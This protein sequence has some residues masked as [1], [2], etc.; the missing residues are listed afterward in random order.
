MK[1]DTP[2]NFL[3]KLGIVTQM[4]DDITQFR[5]RMKRSRSRIHDQ[6]QKMKH[7]STDEGISVEATETIWKLKKKAKHEDL[8]NMKKPLKMWKG[9]KNNLGINKK[10][11]STFRRNSGFKENKIVRLFSVK[12]HILEIQTWAA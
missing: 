8:M 9:H 5:I 11:Y 3:T 7:S 2:T 12:S 4:I 1:E 10:R 6:D